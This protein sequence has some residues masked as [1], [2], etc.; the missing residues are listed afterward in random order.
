MWFPKPPKKVN[1]IPKSHRRV[2]RR[3]TCKDFMGQVWKW[4]ISLLTFLWLKHSSMGTIGRLG[5]V[6][7]P[8]AQEE[9]EMGLVSL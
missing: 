1:V 9:E 5:D 6:F 3:Y 4:Y 8:Y 7:D 2:L